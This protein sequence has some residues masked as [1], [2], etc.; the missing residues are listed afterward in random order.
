MLGMFAGCN[1]CFSQQL[2]NCQQAILSSLLESTAVG[3]R[4]DR[5]ICNLIMMHECISQAATHVL[6]PGP[7]NASCLQMVR[8]SLDVHHLIIAQ[9]PGRL[10]STTARL[11]QARQAVL[12]QPANPRTVMLV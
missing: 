5:W 10:I 7:E 3:A 12:H 6:I 1:V 11:A 9:M 2:P 8:D 4:T